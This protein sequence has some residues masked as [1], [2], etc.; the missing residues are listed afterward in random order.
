MGLGRCA[1]R[2]ASALAQER[3]VARAGTAYSA[4]S[5]LTAQHDPLVALITGRVC[6]SGAAPAGF[7]IGLVHLG[8]VEALEDELA[9]EQPVLERPAVLLHFVAQLNEGEQPKLGR[10]PSPYGR[11]DC[12]AE[13]S[14]LT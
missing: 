11:K 2:P 10:S 4:A 12:A 14:L 9:L 6:A 13:H 3:R 1:Q 7:G 8:D 5:T